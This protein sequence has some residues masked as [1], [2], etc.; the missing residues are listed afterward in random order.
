MLNCERNADDSDRA[1]ESKDEVGQ[2]NPNATDEN[3]DDVEHNRHA[4][5]GGRDAANGS[6]ERKKA[7]ASQFEQL[8]A[9]RDANDGQAKD[10]ARDE[11]PE[12]DHQATTE[13]D[14]KEISNGAHGFRQRSKFITAHASRLQSPHHVTNLLRSGSVPEDHLSI[15][16][17]S[18]CKLDSSDAHQTQES[19]GREIDAADVLNTHFIRPS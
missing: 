1:E 7:Q 15:I 16:S 6:T 12:C 11:I 10:N 18:R 19:I 13:D 4:S 2:C 5:A 14:P 3:P 9:E 8:V 17:G